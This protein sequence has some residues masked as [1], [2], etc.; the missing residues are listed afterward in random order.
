VLGLIPA[1][2]NWKD[3]TATEVVSLSAPTSPAAEA[4]RNLRTSVQFL[5]LDRPFRVL[6]F[7]SPTAAEG[8]TTTVANLGV[9][10]AW[11]GQ[12]VIIVCCDLRRPRI[13][14]FFGLSNGVGF[15]SVL[16]G[17]AS[18][19]EACQLVPGQ[20]RLAVMA[21]GPLPLNP[22]EVLISGRTGELLDSARAQADIVL[23]DCPPVIPVTDAA[24][25]SRRC[26][27]TFL[28]AS[29]RD[30]SGRAVGRAVEVLSQVGA[31]LVGTILNRVTADDGY[32]YAPRYEYYPAQGP[33]MTMNGS[34]GA[35]GKRRQPESLEDLQSRLAEGHG[36]G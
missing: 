11:A 23:L 19:T 4:Y 35:D 12:R 9:A 8:K 3:K 33:A 30:T 25:L 6:E 20:E 27:A 36:G 10:L 7:T 17:Q 18:V 16:L 2:K 32:G 24:V 28:V 15:T 29:A 22:S 14:E 5:A 1:V 13:H 34:G 21:S 26:D 31:P